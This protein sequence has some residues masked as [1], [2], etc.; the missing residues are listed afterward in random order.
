MKEYNLGDDYDGR[1][2][3]FGN[4]PA[5]VKLMEVLNERPDKKNQARKIKRTI[6]S[7]SNYVKSITNMKGELHT[8]THLLRLIYE[9][10]RNYVDGLYY[11]QPFTDFIMYDLTKNILQMKYH[12]ALREVK[13][14]DQKLKKEV[15]FLDDMLAK[16]GNRKGNP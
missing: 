2:F 14:K 6:N 1:P 15:A 10:K 16:I 4:T 3:T 13:K 8:K 9:E 11:A 12:E 5:C 7:F